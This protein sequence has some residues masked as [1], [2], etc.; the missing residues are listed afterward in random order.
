MLIV[1]AEDIIAPPSEVRRLADA[2]GWRYAEV[3]GAAH[4]VPIEQAVSWRKAV[5]S[6]LEAD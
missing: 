4:A 2:S 1:G 5:L 6:F 3:G